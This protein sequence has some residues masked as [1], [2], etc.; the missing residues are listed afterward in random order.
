MQQRENKREWLRLLMRLW[1]EV[2]ECEDRTIA[3]RQAIEKV[4]KR[5]RAERARG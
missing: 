4:R 1:R 5:V 2:V 3:R